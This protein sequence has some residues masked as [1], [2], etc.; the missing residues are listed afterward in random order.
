MK[1][2]NN[3]LI[4]VHE[5]DIRKDGK[6]FVPDNVIKIDECAFWNCSLLKEIII[7]NSVT[8]IRTAAFWKCSSLKEIVIP[9]SV[10]Q[11]GNYAFSGCSSLKKI[12]I[13]SSITQIKDNIFWNCQTLSI[14]HWKNKTYPVRCIDGCCMYILKEKQLVDYNILK[15]SY[16]PKETIVY[17]AEKDNIFA[18]GQTIRKAVSD[19]QFKIR[20]SL[21]VSEHI[22]RIA[23]QGFMNANDYRLLTGACRQGTDFFLSEHN[24]T[25][26]DTMPVEEVLQLTKGFYGY[27]SFQKAAEKILSIED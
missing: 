12:I 19:L 20:E 16:F 7:P 17:V 1:I 24:L 4:A 21:D 14:I 11:I 6:F 25:W 27:E 18:H 9:D 2:K 23:Q 8:E 26:D 5:S 15:C 13:P 22:A 10:N 3:K